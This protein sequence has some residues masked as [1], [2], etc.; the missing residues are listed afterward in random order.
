MAISGPKLTL[1]QYVCFYAH[2]FFMKE[3]RSPRQILT[4]RVTFQAL[5]IGNLKNKEKDVQ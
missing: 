5:S 3:V 1:F 2:N 4:I